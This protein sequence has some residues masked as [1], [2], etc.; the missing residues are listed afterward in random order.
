[1]V[2]MSRVEGLVGINYPV[3]RHGPNWEQFQQNVGVPVAIIAAQML[4]PTHAG[5]EVKFVFR[6]RASYYPI[7][8][9]IQ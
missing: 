5:C 2:E 6:S 4:S 1:M 8:S 7:Y 9:C 3:R